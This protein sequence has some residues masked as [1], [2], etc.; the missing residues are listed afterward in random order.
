MIRT[1]KFTAKSGDLK[2]EITVKHEEKNA[3]TPDT[4][5]KVDTI[6]ND[7]YDLLRKQGYNYSDIKSH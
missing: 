7:V 1:I 5:K 3:Y 2:T 4:K 6:K